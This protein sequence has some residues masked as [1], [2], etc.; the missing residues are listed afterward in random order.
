METKQKKENKQKASYAKRQMCRKE[1]RIFAKEWPARELK[2]GPFEPLWE[3]LQRA[4]VSTSKGYWFHSCVANRSRLATKK[5][6][7]VCSLEGENKKT[8]GSLTMQALQIKSINE[9]RNILVA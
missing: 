6:F 8:D 1:H 2:N 7:P 9:K 4:V 5:L 3:V